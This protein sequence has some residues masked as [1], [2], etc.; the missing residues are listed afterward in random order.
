VATPF[1]PEGLYPPP[2][3]DDV[4]ELS[5]MQFP[6]SAPVVDPAAAAA[7]AAPVAIA[8]EPSLAPPPPPP[9]L[10]APVPPPP[11]AAEPALAPPPI[12]A[13]PPALQP[14][15]GVPAAALEGGLAS[16]QAIAAN[17]FDETTGDVRADISP[18]GLNK[19]LA[20]PVY[21]AKFG[22]GLENL[23]TAREIDAETRI[24]EEDTKARQA[25]LKMQ[26]DAL[27]SVQA[28]SAAIDADAQ[29]IADTKLMPKDPG[30][31]GILMGI[32]GGLIQGKTGSTRNMGID[33]LTDYINRD[34]E[35]QKANLAGAR[36][37]VNLR[38][39]ALANEMA[40]HGD[41]FRAQE[42][43]RLAKLDEAKAVV[44]LER[45]KYAP[46]GTSAL[47]AATLEAGIDAARAEAK[48]KSDQ[49]D[50]EN[51]MK[52]GKFALDKQQ[53]DETRRHNQAGEYIDRLK[54]DSAAEDRALARQQ[55]A[56]DKA[57][58]RADKEA[59][60][61]RRFSIGGFSQVKVGADGKPVI[62]ADGKPEIV[63]DVLRN[64]D[65]SKWRAPSDEA[66]RDLR[67]NKVAGT[68][69]IRNIDRI[70]AIRDRVGG[71][72]GLL[73]SDEFQELEGLGADTTMKLKS[74]TQGMSSDIDMEFIRKSG[75][76]DNVTSWRGQRA[77]LM[78]ARARIEA[79]LNTEFEAAKYSGRKIV[80]P[81]A[82]ATESTLDEIKFEGLL[83]K[84]DE[85]LDQARQQIEE[86]RA[87]GFDVGYNPNASIKQQVGIARLG[88]E[89]TGPADDQAAKLARTRLQKLAA[90]APTSALR[91]LAR[92]TLESALRSGL[93][94]AE[95]TT[96]ASGARGPQREQS[97][98]TEVP[99]ELRAR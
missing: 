42:A 11:P 58:E 61:D 18:A 1:G 55:R 15:L 98:A 81:E 12:D 74:G 56:E 57:L 10:A 21:R 29:R 84:P 26:N 31:A 79:N 50:F 25:N 77:K 73:N 78:A 39:S 95:E 43:V 54:L 67:K 97:S 6:W 3:Y 33:A 91:Q 5:S 68:A 63:Y 66:E 80:F 49:Q 59:E 46:R 44:A 99:D 60:L 86:A 32:I 82:R 48:A 62:G 9:E 83:T 65:G 35:V 89:A 8:P 52:A 14:G 53:Q 92:A 17:P 96:T 70:V 76:V 7:A 38:R 71:E 34:L 4:P 94:S 88:Q 87:G 64:A 27:K 72:N 40:L 51:Y 22:D 24:L 36:E 85:S 16:A 75:G 30:L 45:M 2:F 93:G 23:K 90:E 28:K 47:R 37:G 19:A 69:A 20:D 13:A 41:M